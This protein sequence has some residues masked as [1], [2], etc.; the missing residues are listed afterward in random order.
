VCL[1]F[2]RILVNV[3]NQPDDMAFPSQ[4]H[5]LES[6]AIPSGEGIV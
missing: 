1:R 2:S 4:M 6:Q 5:R 3:E